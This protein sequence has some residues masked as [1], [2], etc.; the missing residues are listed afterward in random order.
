M[1]KSGAVVRR[2]G[3]LLLN[4]LVAIFGTA[5]IEAPLSKLYHPHTIGSVLIR[6][7]LV[8][9]TVAGLMGFFI[10]RRWRSESA[11]WV[12]VV[13][14]ALFVLRALLIALGS[15]KESAWSQMSGLACAEGFASGC[16]NC[17]VITIPAVRT[18][19]YSAG[20]GLCWRLGIHGRSTSED[21]LLA[22]FHRPDFVNSS[23]DTR[24]S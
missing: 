20:A 19:F 17:F 7:Y 18:I 24:A 14:L 5:V 8:S 13:G 1:L 12:W 22:R 4:W 11:K 15:S 2:V 23:D 10:Y 16:M 21:A 3:E 9:A 6:E